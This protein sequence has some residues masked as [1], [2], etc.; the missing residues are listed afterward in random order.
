MKE[1]VLTIVQSTLSEMGSD[2]VNS[3]DDTTEAQ[4][5]ALLLKDVY[6][7]LVSSRTWESHKELTNLTAS[8]VITR[9][10]F[11]LLPDDLQEL[12][13]LRYNCYTS[14]DQKTN[15]QTLTYLYPDAFINLINA[16][17]VDATNVVEISSVNTDQNEGDLLIINDKAPQYWTS[18]DD[19][20]IV[21]DSWDQATG[22]SL[23]EKNN[24]AY[25]RKE[26]T[27]TLADGF[28]IDLPSEAFSLL[29][30][31]AKSRAFFAIK[32]L[33]NPLLAAEEQRQ[34]NRMSRKSWSAHGGIRTADYGRS[35]GRSRIS[36]GR[37]S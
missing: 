24:Q 30:A 20:W 3:I 29:K 1:T 35:R 6:Y 36:N 27:F 5:V 34:R 13:W 31:T 19:Q 32:Q 11:L 14:P 4:R 17:N 10:N 33:G 7:E 15:W 12:I 37:N 25:V 21:T 22:Q 18:F 16:R 2:I 8:N 23:Q 9:P 26:P 28:V